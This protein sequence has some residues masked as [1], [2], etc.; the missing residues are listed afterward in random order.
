ML[1]QEEDFYSVL[2]RD[3]RFAARV[4]NVVV[5]FGG[6][7]AQDVIDRYVAGEEVP[8]AELRVPLVRSRK[9]TGS[10]DAP[11]EWFP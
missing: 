3:P 10:Y 6:E 9:V 8:L 4:S 1:A 11:T 5:E 7:V 2:V